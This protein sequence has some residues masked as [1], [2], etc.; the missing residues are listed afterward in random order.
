MAN[1]IYLNAKKGRNFAIQH[2][3]K[4]TTC[5]PD[6]VERASRLLQKKKK[7]QKKDF[8]NKNILCI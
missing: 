8:L 3:E 7:Q 4:K 2:E 5:L 1:Y 6:I